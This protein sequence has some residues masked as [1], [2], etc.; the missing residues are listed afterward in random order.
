MLA[1]LAAVIALAALEIYV[2]VLVA[3]AIG[4]ALTLVALVASTAAGLWLVRSQRRRAWGA[5]R[6][7]V[8]SG[9]IPDR[10][11]ADA[12]LILAGGT[13]IAVPGFVT[14]ALGVLTVAPLTRPVLR[15]LL[16]ILLFRRAAVAAAGLRVLRPRRARRP[17]AGGQAATAPAGKVIRAE[18]IDGGTAAE[19][20]GTRPRSQAGDPP[21]GDGGSGDVG[22]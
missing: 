2:I 7:A 13:L 6:E 18:V 19:R 21:A 1:A 15:R 8:A 20:S 5:L 17:A 4:V 9:A 22:R 12:A 14:D 11:L 16:A 3:H 10:E